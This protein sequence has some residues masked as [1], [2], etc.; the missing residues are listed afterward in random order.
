MNSLVDERFSSFSSR[1]SHDI[2]YIRNENMNGEDAGERTCF[3]ALHTVT[4]VTRIAP[5]FVVRCAGHV[6]ALGVG[7]TSV[8]HVARY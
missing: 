1:T 5:A 6:D 7:V 4:L 2:R 3:Y 8:H